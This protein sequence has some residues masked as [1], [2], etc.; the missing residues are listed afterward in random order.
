MLGWL[1]TPASAG[2]WRA[3]ELGS[4]AVAGV[5]KRTLGRETVGALAACFDAFRDL[6]DGFHSRATRVAALKPLERMMA[7]G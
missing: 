1:V 5:F 2:A 4:E 3:L 7:L 6:W